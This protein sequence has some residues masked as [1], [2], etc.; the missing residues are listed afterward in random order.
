MVLTLYH[1]AVRTLA[2][3]FLELEF[4]EWN[5]VDR[6]GTVSRDLV[7]KGCLD[8]SLLLLGVF[9]VRDQLVRCVQLQE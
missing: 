1:F 9:V 5:V 7:R 2:Y 8:G 3:H 4:L 6:K